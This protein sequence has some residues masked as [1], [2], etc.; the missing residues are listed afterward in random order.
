MVDTVVMWDFDGTLAY[1]TGMWRSALLE[2]L[3]DVAPGHGLTL[4]DVGPGLRSRFP[5]HRPDLGHLDLRTAE[6]WWAAVEPVFVGAY[7]QAGVA[8]PTARAA[9]PHVRPRYTD[10]AGWT[11][12]ADSVAALTQ[13]AGSGM[14]QIVV[15]NHVPELPDLMA[16]LGLAGYFDAILTS[17]VTGWEKPNPEMYAIARQAAGCP[18]RLWMIGDNPRADIEGAQAIGIPAILVRDSAA[19]LS[20]TIASVFAVGDTVA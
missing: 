19:D 7:E 11:V 15:S 12:F 20:A 18:D 16:A 6:A 8:G 17:A 4:D 2:A 13:V 9:A 14:R 5:W 3:T 1:R 10:P